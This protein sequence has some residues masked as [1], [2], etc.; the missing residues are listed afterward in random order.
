MSFYVFNVHSDTPPHPK[1]SSWLDTKAV[2]DIIKNCTQFFQNVFDNPPIPF[3]L[4]LGNHDYYP[5]D[6]LPGEEN[7]IYEA[8]YNLWQPWLNSSDIKETFLRGQYERNSSQ[9]DTDLKPLSRKIINFIISR[10]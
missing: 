6:Q 3:V 4:S 10:I 1:D 8:V 2:L 7:F 5:V 9:C